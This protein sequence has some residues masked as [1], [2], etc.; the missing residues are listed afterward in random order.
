VV[1]VPDV[2]LRMRHASY[3]RMIHAAE[4]PAEISLHDEHPDESHEAGHQ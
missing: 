4:V 3:E 1:L 2:G